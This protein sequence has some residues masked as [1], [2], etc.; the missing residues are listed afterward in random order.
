MR[1]P[2]TRIALAVLTV[3][4]AMPTPVPAAPP[5]PESVELAFLVGEY[6]DLETHLEPVRQGG[7]EI[8]WSSPEHRIVVHRNLLTLTRPPDATDGT[9]DASFEVEFEGEGQLVAEITGAGAPRQLHDDVSAE[10]QTVTV[11]GR[12]RLARG[13]GGYTLEIVEAPPSVA[14]RIRSELA[15]QIVSLCQV[16]EKIPFLPVSCRGLDRA[17]SVVSVPLPRA[18]ETFFLAADRLTASEIEVF[19]AW[20]SKPD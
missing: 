10:R 12:I 1:A 18:G 15:G 16:L 11:A 17:L 7:L 9:A 8:R 2:A 4:L 5:G 14:L 3:A 20:C 6:T 13:D 19:D